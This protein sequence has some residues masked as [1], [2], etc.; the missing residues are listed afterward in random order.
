[1][2]MDRAP[3]FASLASQLPGVWNIDGNIAALDAIIDSW[4]ATNAPADIEYTFPVAAIDATL[5]AMVSSKSADE[6]EQWV[7]PLQGACAKYEITTI[8]RVAAFITTLAHEAGFKVGARENMNYS[9]ERLSQVW[10]HRY[11]RRGPNQKARSLH[12]NPEAIANDVYANRMGNG[13]ASSG[14]GWR[15]RGTGPIQLTGRNNFTAFADHLDIS[16]EQAEALI[17]TVEGGIQ[18]AAWF[19]DEND[20]NRLA[21]TPGIADETRRINGGTNGIADRK[22]KFDKL[23]D[24]LLERERAVEG[25][26]G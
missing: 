22:R 3:I 14:D 21:D 23:V 19:W 1:M 10:P 26:F 6:L 25:E 9:A 13:P 7:A 12:R 11:G 2:T 17:L 8:R 16:L 18:S 4:E 20:I 5:L 15:F 24:E